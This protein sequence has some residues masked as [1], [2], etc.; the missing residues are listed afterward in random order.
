MRK[1]SIFSKNYDKEVKRRKIII[2]T[3]IILPIIGL[4]IFFSTDFNALLNKG[5]SMKNGI[6][7]ILS[8]KSKDNKKDEQNKA[9]E[10]KKESEKV[11]R[12]AGK[13]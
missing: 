8:N 12:K 5:I 1:P 9:A 13:F 11:V 10:V 3:L 4:G 7:S 2:I 6:N